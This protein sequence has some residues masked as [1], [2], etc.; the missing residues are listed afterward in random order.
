M[1]TPVFDKSSLSNFHVH[2][3]VKQKTHILYIY[4]QIRS[5]EPRAQEI[6]QTLCFSFFEMACVS[7]F[8]FFLLSH[9]FL[10]HS[11]EGVNKT[12][13][14]CSPFQCGKF[15]IIDFPFTNSSQP[16]SFLLPIKCDEK[17][18]TIQ[19]GLS[20]GQYEV[21]N[22]S[23]TNTKQSTRI[24]D[25]LLYNDLVNQ[26]CE[27]LTNFTIPNSPFISFKLT[28]PSLTLFKCNRTLG[29]TS[30]R[31]FTNTSCGDYNLYYSHLSDNSPSFPSECSII[32]LPKKEHSD[33][34]T[35][36]SILSA[37]FDLEVHASDA[38]SRCYGGAGLCVLDKNGKFQCVIAEKGIDI[39]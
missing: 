19:L 12:L 21:I 15:G 38:C 6:I 17:P 20:R 28:T 30:P 14:N 26:N 8:V 24:K 7:L 22:I 13:P 36:F 31:N 2:Y 4:K 37:E 5:C 33:N 34:D 16:F 1:N 32:Q 11:A 18:P 39:E 23:Y 25:P 29:I 9:L 10:L 27:S 3:R 35:L